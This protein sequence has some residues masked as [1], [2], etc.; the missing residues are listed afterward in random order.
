MAG[1]CLRLFFFF[2]FDGRLWRI[3]VSSGKSEL[4]DVPPAALNPTIA[5]LTGRLVYTRYI[6]DQDLWILHPG[7]QPER[8]ALSTYLDVS[9]EFSPDGRKIAFSSGRSG[10]PRIWVMN[11]DGT[12]LVA[13]TKPTGRLQGSPRWSRDGRRIAFD[14]SGPDAQFGIYVVDADGGP[15]KKVS[16]VPGYIPSW[17]YDGKWV[18]FTSTHSGRTEVWKSPADG[19]QSVQVTH[20]GAQFP[21]ESANRFSV[22]RQRWS[23]VSVDSE[24]G[25]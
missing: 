15:E 23:A 22:L 7:S 12:G 2:R 8:F 9:A 6:E 20:S 24:G 10:Q 18:Y 25:R 1:A 5:R 17:S 21:R 11:S 13:L 4:L 16:S 14:A 19:G 3:S